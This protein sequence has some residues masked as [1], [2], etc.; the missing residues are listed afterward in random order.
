VT[1]Y[2]PA[3]VLADLLDA[4]EGQAINEC[5]GCPAC[6]APPEL[7]ACEPS[8]VLDTVLDVLQRHGA[9]FIDNDAYVRGRR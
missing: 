9:V 6:G 3:A 8:E 2:D 5:P 7:K 1:V 4:L